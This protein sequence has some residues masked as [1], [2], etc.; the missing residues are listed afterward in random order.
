MLTLVISL[1]LYTKVEYQELMTSN[2][3]LSLRVNMIVAEK[4]S[5]SK[6]QMLALHMVMNILETV[7][8]SLLRH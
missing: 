8:D 6:L 1:K 4:I 5:S 2:G 7:Q 3:K